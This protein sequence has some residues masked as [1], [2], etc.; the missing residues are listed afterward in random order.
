[1]PTLSALI[2]SG[3]S[4]RWICQ[5]CSATG[6]VD[7]PALMAAA[8][9]IGLTDR[10]PPCKAEGCTYWVGFYAQ[11]GMRNT[12]LRTPAGD[13]RAMDRRSAWLSAKW[14]SEG[15]QTQKDPATRR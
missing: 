6:P 11:Q 9:D 2:A 15:L 3:S 12:P 13:L 7:L 10:H 14:A 4:V 5:Q 1:M 8:G